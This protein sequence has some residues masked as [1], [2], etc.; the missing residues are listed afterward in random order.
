MP[1]QIE[2]D[3]RRVDSFLRH[4]ALGLLYGCHRTDDEPARIAQCA[5]EVIR[6]E[7]FVLQDEY[8]CILE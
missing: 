1:A 8:A 6:E 2:I 5:G 7:A 4:Q 3:N